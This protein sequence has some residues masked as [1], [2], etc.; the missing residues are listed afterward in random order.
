M[1][2]RAKGRRRGEGGREE[3]GVE[4]G[5]VARDPGYEAN[6]KCSGDCPRDSGPPSA[7]VLGARLDEFCIALS[8]A[9]DVEEVNEEKE[10]YKTL[11]HLAS[12]NFKFVSGSRSSSFPKYDP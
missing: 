6:W 2:N 10:N 9:E 8:R 1:A 12:S 3:A 7:V 5:D 11:E 4:T